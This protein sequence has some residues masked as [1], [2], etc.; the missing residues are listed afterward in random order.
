MYPVW[1]LH[2]FL[3]VWCNRFQNLHGRC[4]PPDQRRQEG[5][6]DAGTGDRGSVWTGYYVC[7]LENS[8]KEDWVCRYDRGWSGRRYDRGSEVAMRNS[9]RRFLICNQ[10]DLFSLR[11]KS[12]CEKYAIKHI[13]HTNL[14]SAGILMLSK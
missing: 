1:R 14:H 13:F 12:P 7:K 9:R 11:N 2:P 10:G 4:D 8:F 3:P 6:S 5:R